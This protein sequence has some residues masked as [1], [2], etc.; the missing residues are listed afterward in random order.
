[1]YKRT[2]GK[3]LTKKQVESLVKE[4]EEAEKREKEFDPRKHRLRHGIR[5]PKDSAENF[6]GKGMRLG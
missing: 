6:A 5:N 4:Y 1:M 2:D 3:K